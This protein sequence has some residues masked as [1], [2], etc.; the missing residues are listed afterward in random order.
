MARGLNRCEF[1]GNLGA[2]PELK[3]TPAGIAV[4]NFSICC[5]DEWVDKEGEK[6]ESAEWIR[7]VA[8]RGLAEKVICKFCRKG[9]RIWCEGKMETREWE[10]ADGIKRW[11]TE[12]VIDD[13]RL[14]G[15]PSGGSR[16][17]D[18]PDD[19]E[20]PPERGGRDAQYDQAQGDPGVAAGQ[21]PP[22]GDPDDNY[23]DSDLPF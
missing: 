23:D 4:C 18:P 20:P 6:H 7:L 13:V 11:S 8:W 3:F 1:I 5:N 15:D 19:R 12:I 2:D 10:D 17:D 14:L 16:P 21:D 9:S 22:P